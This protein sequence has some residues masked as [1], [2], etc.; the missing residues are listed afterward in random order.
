MS[1]PLTLCT[2]K[3]VVKVPEVDGRN[4]S[5]KIHFSVL[6]ECSVGI[7]LQLPQSLAWHRTIVQGRLILVAP[8]RPVRNFFQV[9]SCT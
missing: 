8:R 3:T 4:A 2:C 9:I 1:D 5:L 6:V 7:D